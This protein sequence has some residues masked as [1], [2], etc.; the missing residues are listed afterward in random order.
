VW[1]LSQFLGQLRRPYAD[2]TQQSRHQ[3]HMT[4]GIGGREEEKVGETIRRAIMGHFIRLTGY[5]TMEAVMINLRR[6]V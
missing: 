2:V 5:W 6:P 3:M 1:Y 4:W